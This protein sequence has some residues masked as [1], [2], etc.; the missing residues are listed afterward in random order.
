MLSSFY[1]YLTSGGSNHSEP[2]LLSLIDADEPVDH[3]LSWLKSSSDAT[4]RPCFQPQTL[5]TDKDLQTRIR[6]TETED[7]VR[8]VIHLVVAAAR[9]AIPELEIYPCAGSGPSLSAA[10]ASATSAAD[11]VAPELTNLT[12]SISALAT[13]SEMTLSLDEKTA[14]TVARETILQCQLDQLME[15]SK[16]LVDSSLNELIKASFF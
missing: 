13:I 11:A 10:T 16:F 3:G 1:Q 9:T 7:V 2:G 8:S 4:K 14:I 6:P 15:E 12:E 5:F